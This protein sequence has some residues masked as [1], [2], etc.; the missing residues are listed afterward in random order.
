MRIVFMGTPEYAATILEEISYQHEILCA[1]T[2]P[3][4][5]R[6]RGRALV[7]SPVKLRANE[8]NIPVREPRSLKSTEEVQVLKNLNP[9]IVVVAAYGMILPANILSVPKFGCINAHA[10][11]LPRWRGAAPIERA[12][13]AGDAQAGVCV[14]RIEEGLDTGA[15]CVS[16][17]TD[18]ADKTCA[19]LTRELAILGARAM[20]T[21]LSQIEAGG[22]RWE[23][24]D[25]ARVT[26]ANKIEKHELDVSP[27]DACCT[28]L[29]KCRASSEA[30]ACKAVVGGKTVTL[31]GLACASPISQ[32]AGAHVPQGSVALVCKR[33]VLGFADGALEVTS[34]KPDGKREMTGAAFAAGLQGI[35]SGRITW[36]ACDA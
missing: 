1:Y 16:R 10:S 22:E 27:A 33:L 14:M 28:A 21:A 5:V 24:Q 32:E 8:L 19:E 3:D 35:K 13:L 6:G 17:T 4:A 29:R 18:I 20:L 31:L 9:D 23:E 36:S 26:Y 2:R 34:L 15:Y 7:P 11:E 30:H 12:I 25:E